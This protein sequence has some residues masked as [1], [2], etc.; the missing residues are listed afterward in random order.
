MRM[1][2]WMCGDT[3][4]DKIRNKYMRGTIKLALVTKKV[5]EKAEVVRT[6]EE[7]GPVSRH[8]CRDPSTRLMHG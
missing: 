1:L 2:R 6:H 7:E 3:K 4:N 5:R 8:V